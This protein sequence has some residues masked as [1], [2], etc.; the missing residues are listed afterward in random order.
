MLA[1]VEDP[2]H[3]VLVEHW[4]SLEA[5]DAYRAWRASEGESPL[6]PLLTGSRTLTRY[7]D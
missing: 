4:A 1:D 3:V 7:R 2:G 5:E 6:A